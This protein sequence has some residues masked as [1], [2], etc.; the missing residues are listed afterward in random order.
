MLRLDKINVQV[1]LL[2]TAIA[3]G[4]A[5]VGVIELDYVEPPPAAMIARARFWTIGLDVD[6]EKLK[7]LNGD[8]SRTPEDAIHC[9]LG[10]NLDLLV[11]ANCMAC[12]QDQN[13]GKKIVFEHMFEAD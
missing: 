8:T 9:F 7:L 3:N 2:G 5:T 13:P 1:Q 11:I 12:K 10:S 6:P 4:S